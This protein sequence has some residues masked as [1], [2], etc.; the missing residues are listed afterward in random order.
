MKPFVR[1]NFATSLDGRIA[2]RGNQPFKFSN[3]EDMNRVHKMR[4]ESDAIL[5]GR[6]T[7]N[8]DDPK[9]VIS[10]KYYASDRIPD[11]M[12]M[13][14]KLNVNFEAR[15]FSYKRNVVILTGK[16]ALSKPAVKTVSK[17]LIKKS[18]EDSPSPE[19]AIQVAAELGYKSVMVEGGMSI[20]T[21]FLS[22]KLWDEATIFYSP[23]IVGDSGI[24]MTSELA[25]MI[26]TKIE[27]IEVIGNGFVVWLKKY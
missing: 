5:V 23:V 4:A 26:N 24:P 18:Q 9:L 19:F 17:V 12:I 21:S 1:I 6:N 14:S 10:S 27:K 15:V 22:S 13:D 7:I 25:Q 8:G 20:L 3:M 2:L 11:V 16:N